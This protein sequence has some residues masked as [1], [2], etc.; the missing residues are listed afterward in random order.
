MSKSVIGFV[1]SFVLLGFASLNP[2]LADD[3]ESRMTYAVA[4]TVDTDDAELFNSA[5]AMQATKVLEL[6]KEGLIE[7]VYIDGEKDHGSVQKGDAARVLFF[8]KADSEDAAKA[9]LDEL[10][11]VQ[12]KAATYTL[13]PVGALWLKQY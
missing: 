11:L 6:W 1:F 3:S 9:V 4:W 12:E 2:A 8:V 13:T 5:V 7:N 10:P